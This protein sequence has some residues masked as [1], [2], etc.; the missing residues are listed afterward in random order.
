VQNSRTPER[1]NSTEIKLTHILLCPPTTIAQSLERTHLSSPD[2]PLLTSAPYLCSYH[3]HH[4]PLFR[5]RTTPS[6]Y[7]YYYI[8]S[9][10]NHLF[11]PPSPHHFILVAIDRT[12]TLTLFYLSIPRP[13]SLVS[14][15]P[16][17]PPTTSSLSLHI[18]IPP[19][20]PS[21][22][23]TSSERPFSKSAIRTRLLHKLNLNP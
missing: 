3:D 4:L 11:Y 2:L 5:T 22:P 17:I 13:S 1:Q 7:Q 20:Q 14:H 18:I 23:S 12:H 10:I 6:T 16:I 9:S 21:Y 8:V 15:P 19:H